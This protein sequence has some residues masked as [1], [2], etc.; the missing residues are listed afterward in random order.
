MNFNHEDGLFLRVN[1][2]FQLKVA[3]H[4]VQILNESCSFV[5]I[6]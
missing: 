5:G 4:R 3:Y 1:Q 6:S 2:S